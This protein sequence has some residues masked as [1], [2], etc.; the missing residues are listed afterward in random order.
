MPAQPVSGVTIRETQ[1]L[2][3]ATQKV[4]P[5]LVATFKVG[6]HGPFQESFPKNGTDS[7]AIN[8]K[9]AEFANKIGLIQ[10]Q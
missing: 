7:N 9:L 3:P 6:N 1:Q 5:Y 10:G 2:N 4:E 8:A